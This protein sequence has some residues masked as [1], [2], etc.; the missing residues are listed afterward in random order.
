VAREEV[1]PV[2]IIELIPH[3]D[4]GDRT[5]WAGDQDERPLSDLGRKQA[6]A[7]AQA[8]TKSPI[9]ALF[10][11]PAIRCRES[12]EPLA[13]RVKLPIRILG[14]L[15]E[16]QFGEGTPTMAQRGLRA[17]EEVV[18]ECPDGR[19]VVC[20][21]GDII[22]ATAGALARK[23]GI[24]APALERRGQWY[25]LRFQGTELAIE[26]SSAESIRA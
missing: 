5:R 19:A 13:R 22:P 4:A 16:K 15:A 9:D 21:H 7:V 6:E 24:A 2:L 12:L 17:I 18:A 23:H 1:R 8:L 26:L 11:S 14:D 10:S 25:S 3:L 20:S